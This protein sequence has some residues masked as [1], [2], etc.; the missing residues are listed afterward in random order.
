MITKSYAA[1]RWGQI[2]LR[3]AGQAIPP[4]PALLLL[5]P[6]PKSGWVWEPLMA[7][8]APDHQILAPDTP[9]YGASDP[10]PAPVSIGDYAGEMLAMIERL[11]REDALPGGP[12]DVMGYHTGSVIA[13]EMAL[14]AP[15][16]VRRILFTSLPV[17]SAE[18]RATKRAGLAQWRGPAEDGSHLMAMWTRMQGLADPRTDT[19]WKH[20]SFAENLRCGPRA[21]WGY[22][23]VYRYDLE[24]ALRRLHH[25]ALVLNPEDDLWHQTQRGIAFLPDARVAELPGVGH[26][27]FALETERIA[28]LVRDFLD[29]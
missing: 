14:A 23:A 22:D 29:P 5:H 7:A 11:H 25:P 1:G 3:R 15:K 8:L 9:G 4:R 2:H 24:A 20:A 10:P 12:I 19:G 28:R 16:R 26:G 6:T 21:P 17:Y 13:A 18:E 27:L